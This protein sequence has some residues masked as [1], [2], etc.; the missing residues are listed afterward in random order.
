MTN[1][2]QNLSESVKALEELVDKKLSIM[3]AC[4][5]SEDTV[6]LSSQV[7]TLQAENYSVKTELEELKQSYK[8]LK[9]TSRD[10]INE[11]NHSIQVI[12]DYFKKE[13]ASN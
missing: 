13:N 8:V 2:L 7:E 3:N 6:L 9:D 11:L 4:N 12:E 10:V 1:S 5:S